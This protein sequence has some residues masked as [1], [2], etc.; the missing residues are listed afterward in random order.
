MEREINKIAVIGAGL[1]G[2]AWAAFYAGPGIRWALM[3]QHMTYHLGGGPGGIK[4][5]VDHIGENKRR[6]CE[7]MAKWTQLP[8]ETKKVLAEGIEQEMGEKSFKEVEQW[9]D[10]KL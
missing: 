8:S 10:E 2:S 9:R 7:D 6:L 1:V 3:G 5:F 4:H